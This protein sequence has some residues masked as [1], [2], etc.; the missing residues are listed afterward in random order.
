MKR[1]SFV[2]LVVS[3]V[4]SST[5]CLQEAADVG[6]AP[7]GGTPSVAVETVD[8]KDASAQRCEPPTMFSGE[9]FDVEELDSA[10]CDDPDPVDE[11]E[12]SAATVLTMIALDAERFHAVLA[13]TYPGYDVAK[14]DALRAQL[15]ADGG[16]DAFLATAMRTRLGSAYP[17][18]VDQ[19]TPTSD[20]S[21][22]L[23]K[24]GHLLEKRLNR[25]V[26]APGDEGAIF[27]MAIG[28]E[29][30]GLDSA[31]A[32]QVL[33]LKSVFDTYSET[34]VTSNLFGWVR[35][36]WRWTTARLRDGWRF[37]RRQI[38]RIDWACVANTVGVS[39]AC[40][41]C[42]ASVVAAPETAGGTLTAAQALCGA[43]CVAG[44]VRIV[45]SGLCQ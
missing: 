44:V 29:L 39:A 30:E 3:L 11:P 7:A 1:P 9:V 10:D 14:G 4:I 2:G 12:A 40:A 8:D 15:I 23:E 19:L 36:A 38:G 6:S 18:W 24:V 32:Q 45:D 21:Q 31:L 5:G 27:A 35:R 34:A 41:G 16:V 22:V 42:V 33:D 17:A 20:T 37:V 28:L 43:G 26:D 13:T 25:G